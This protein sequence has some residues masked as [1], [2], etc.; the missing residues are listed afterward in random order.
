MTM[1]SWWKAVCFA[2]FSVVASGAIAGN[3]VIIMSTASSSASAANSGDV[4]GWHIY[5]VLPGGSYC[6]DDYADEGLWAPRV[7]IADEA[8]ELSAQSCPT[9]YHVD[10]VFEATRSRIEG[11]GAN[12][13]VEFLGRM[14][15]RV[16]EGCSLPRELVVVG[17]ACLGCDKTKRQGKAV[18]ERL[19]KV[20]SEKLK[21][22]VEY[23]I[24]TRD[25]FAALKGM[26]ITTQQRV[27]DVP[28]LG[29]IG[30]TAS[31]SG[32]VQSGQVQ[33]GGVQ[34][35]PVKNPEGDFSAVTGD[36]AE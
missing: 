16:S 8:V 1:N 34:D 21:E 17:Y 14:N 29:V 19:A 23:L 3:S 32:H 2:V 5:G 36:L 25:D 10:I 13:L 6:C 12:A 11:V 27:V 4:A 35:A 9:M 31:I 24:D 33:T 18:V 22:A 28:T 20:R 30:K 26:T 7:P 15:E